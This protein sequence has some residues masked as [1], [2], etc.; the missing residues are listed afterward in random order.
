MP[1]LTI[2]PDDTASAR[3]DL[4]ADV[5][6]ELRRGE[7]FAVTL[8]RSAA[9]MLHVLASSVSE[10]ARTEAPVRHRHLGGLRDRRVWTRLSAMRFIRRENDR[11]LPTVAGIGAAYPYLAGLDSGPVSAATLRE[12]RRAELVA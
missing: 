1:L 9:R 4:D 12:L 2:S 10:E 6:H 11:I 7:V 3:S 8:P 5:E